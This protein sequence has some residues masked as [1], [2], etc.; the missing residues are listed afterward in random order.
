MSPDLTAAIG[1][2]VG[3]RARRLGL[4]FRPG[5]LA[6]ALATVNWVLL[7]SRQGW[8]FDHADLQ[9]RRLCYSD[10]MALWG[11]RGIA[12]GRV[13]YL[14]SD[15]EYP[16]LTGGFIYLTRR[17]S[18]LLDTARADVTFFGLTSALLFA[19]FLALVWVHLRLG[20]PAAAIMVAASPLVTASG[21]INWDLL[22]VALASGSLLAWARGRPALAGVLIGL[23]TAAKLYPVLFLVPIVVLSL[24]AG[25]LRAAR[26]AVLAAFGAW[27]AANLPVIIAAPAGWWNFWS[28]NADRGGDLGSLWYVWTSRGGELPSLSA[29][30]AGAMVLGTAALVALWLAAPRRPRLA[31]AVFLIMLL[32]LLVNKVYSPQYMLWLLPL[33]VLAR[34]VWRDWLVLTFGELVYYGAV[35]LYLDGGLYAGDGQPRL[36]WVAVLVRVACEVWVGAHV[37]RDVLEPWDDPVRAGYV[38][39]PTGGVLDGAPDAGRRVGLREAP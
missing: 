10:V 30:V 32:F 26:A 6:Y 34:P 19:C 28:F 21:L 2:P 8:C 3:R 7:M 23:G 36:Y 5:P 24:R 16:M 25:R 39:D 13:P 12:E 27:A 38:D 11:V 37:V 33:A 14:E 29:A 4:W 9:Y 18:G 1:G 17:L 20:H 15:L 35:W 22:V 31:Q